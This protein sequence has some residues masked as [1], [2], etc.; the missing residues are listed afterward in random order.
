MVLKREPRLRMFRRWATPQKKISTS[1][2][3]S[4]LIMK[5]QE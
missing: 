4:G 1:R 5:H 3:A 2:E